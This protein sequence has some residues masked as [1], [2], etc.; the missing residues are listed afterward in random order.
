MGLF[1]RFVICLSRRWLD[2]NLMVQS[3][4]HDENRTQ[5][6][7]DNRRFLFNLKYGLFDLCASVFIRVPFANS[8]FTILSG[9]VINLNLSSPFNADQAAEPE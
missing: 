5:I 1:V 7:T 2:N 3:V 9:F 8:K 6:F 4:S